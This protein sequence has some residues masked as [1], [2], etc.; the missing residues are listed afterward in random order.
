[1]AR[2]R[3]LDSTRGHDDEPTAG[4]EP[5]EFKQGRGGADV[6][7]FESGP[8]NILFAMNRLF[9][10]PINVLF[11]INRLLLSPINRLFAADLCWSIR[12]FPKKHNMRAGEGVG[13]WLVRWSCRDGTNAPSPRLLS[14]TPRVAAGTDAIEACSPGLALPWIP[15]RVCADWICT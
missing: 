10:S 9:L 5:V 14:H 15:R 13:M 7:C 4:F 11:A 1:M 6:C 3:W 12:D 2:L 8:I